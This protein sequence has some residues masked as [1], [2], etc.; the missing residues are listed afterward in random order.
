MNDYRVDFAAGDMTIVRAK[1]I[2]HARKWV[3][4]KSGR[5]TGAVVRSARNTD[6]S[7]VLLNNGIIH[8]AK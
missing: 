6:V 5:L 3:K 1:T 8:V 2:R 4:E 7:L